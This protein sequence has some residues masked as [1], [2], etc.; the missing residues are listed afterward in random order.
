MRNMVMMMISIT[1][2]TLIMMIVMTVTGRMNYASE[3]NSQLPSVV[4]ESV[5]HLVSQEKIKIGD[6][7]E[8]LAQM[9]EKL[10]ESLDGVTD[11]SVHVAGA[12]VEKGLLSVKTVRQFQHPNGETGMVCADR[13]V[14]LERQE[15][16]EV[17]Q[18]KVLFF[19]DEETKYKEYELFEGM[20]IAMPAAP[21][22]K[23]KKFAGWV[24]EKGYMADFSQPV[25]QNITYYAMWE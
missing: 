16:K 18:C 21:S 23:G 20:C 8:I 10:A 12:D 14:I 24:D 17:Q 5:S 15:E 19:L 9:Q 2:G 11:L 3:L 6:Q 7:E 4:E 1:I 22:K 25:L 13:T